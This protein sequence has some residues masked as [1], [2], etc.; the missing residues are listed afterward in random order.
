MACAA[1]ADFDK[2]TA[3]SMAEAASMEAL[4]INDPK[5]SFLDAACQTLR[6]QL[7]KPTDKFQAYF[8]ALF[9]DK[10]YTKLLELEGAT[11]LLPLP[12]HPPLSPLVGQELFVSTGESRA[13]LPP[14]ASVSASKDIKADLVPAP[15]LFHTPGHLVLVPARA[16]AKAKVQAR[17]FRYLILLLTYKDCCQFNVTI[18]DN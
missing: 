5:A 13:M 18:C 4:R 6:A 2:Y 12:M 10:D 8:L 17:D 1:A 9:S 11:H 3:V 14:C 7:D 15:A 16:L